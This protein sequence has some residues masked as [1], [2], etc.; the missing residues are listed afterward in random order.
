MWCFVWKLNGILRTIDRD[1]VTK[2]HNSHI[3]LMIIFIDYKTLKWTIVCSSSYLVLAFSGRVGHVRPC[4]PGLYSFSEVETYPAFD[5][6]V[7]SVR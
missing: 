2:T 1:I 7:R 5:S 6:P 4:N 3:H